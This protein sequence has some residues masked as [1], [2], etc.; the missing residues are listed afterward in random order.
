M[1]A[2]VRLFVALDATTKTQEKLAALVDW[3]SRSSAS[4]AAWSL[5]FLSGRKLPQPIPLKRLRALASTLAEISPWLFE[6]AY[7]A[8]GDLAETVALLLPTDLA[9]P[10]EQSQPKAASGGLWSV[11]HGPLPPESGLAAWVNAYLQPL[12]GADE[13]TQYRLLRRAW[14]QLDPTGRFVW[15]KLLTGGFRVGISQSLVTRAVAEASGLPVDL[16]AHRLMGDWRPT[17]E[18][19]TRLVSTEGDQVDAAR[20]YPFALAQSLVPPGFGASDTLFPSAIGQLPGQPED[21]L[22]EWKW[23]GIRAQLVRRS[24]APLLWSRGDELLTDRF[25][26]LHTAARKLPEG[27]VLDGELIAWRDGQVLPFTLLQKRIMRKTLSRS[28]LSE[29]PCVF[30]A[31]DLLEH[32]GIDWRSRPLRERRAALEQLLADPQAERNAAAEHDPAPSSTIRIADAFYGKSPSELTALRGESRERGVEGLML[33]RLDAPYCAGRDEAGWWKWKVDPY[34][35]DAVLVAAQVG[36]GRRANL[37]TDYTFAV[38]EGETLVPFAKAYSGLTDAELKEI[39]ALV[40]QTTVDKFGPVRSVTPQLVFELAFENLQRSSRHKSGIAVRFPRILRRR[41]DKSIRDADTLE[42]VLALLPPE[43]SASV[44]SRE[45]GETISRQ[46][47]FAWAE[48]NPNAG[49]AR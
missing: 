7:A 44:P 43:S 38:W 27:T 32:N 31:F 6:E 16:V 45:Q 39:D 48:P 8:V 22:A 26:E 15:N 20:P 30:V 11:D 42:R 49:D 35:V 40:R 23:D 25:P 1:E 9:E 41:T 29:I 19:Y 13:A 24:G 46:R 10:A 28:I 21:Y 3:F 36:H 4:D 37:F 33:K 5:F 2:F 18:F 34:T 12:R 17:A 47:T 14:S